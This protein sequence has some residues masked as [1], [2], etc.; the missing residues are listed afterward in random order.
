MIKSSAQLLGE[1]DD[2]ANFIILDTLLG[3]ETH[4]M[5]FIKLPSKPDVNAVK[6]I[7]LMYRKYGDEHTVLNELINLLGSWWH[8]FKTSHSAPQV[9]TQKEHLLHYMRIFDPDSGFA[10]VP[11]TRYTTEEVGAKV[12][13]T[14]KWES[15]AKIKY[16]VGCIAEL[17]EEEETKLLVPGENDFSVMF[18]TRKNCSQLWLGPAA[19]IN[20]DCRPNCKFVS[21][22]RDTACIKVLRDVEIG[23]ELACYYGDDYFG[24]NNIYCECET[25]E[26]RKTGFFVNFNNVNSNNNKE[27]SSGKY[28]L[29]ETVKRLS[30]KPKIVEGKGKHP[31]EKPSQQ[32]VQKEE[33]SFEK[34]CT[35]CLSVIARGL[36]HNCKEATRR[37]NLK[38][39]AL[40]DPLG[41]EQI[42]SFIVSSKE[43]SSDGTILISRFHGKPLEI[44]PG[45][46]AT[47]GLSS[48]PLTTQDMINIQQN[49]GLSNNGMRKL[50]SALNQISP[51]RIVE[52]NF[53]Q[54]FAAAETTLKSFFT[55][56]TSQLPESNETRHIVHCTNLETLK[57]NIVSSRGLQN[58][59]FLKLGID[60]G[61]SFFKASLSLISEHEGEPHSPVQ[62]KSKLI[63]KDNFK[64]TKSNET[65]HIVHCTNLETLKENI[66]SSRGL[67]NSNFLKLG[68]DG[69]GSFFK[70]SLSLIS[71][72]E[73]EPH[74]PVQK[75]SKLITKDNFKNTSVQK[76]LIVT[77]SE[78]TPETYPNVKHILDLLQINEI[79]ISE[80]LVI[81]C[82]MKLANIVCGIQSHSSKHPCCWCNIDS[83]HLENCG[84][85]R[86]FGGIRDLYKKFVKSGCDAKRSKEFENVVHLPMFA[87]PDRELILET[88]PPMELHLLL[89]VVNHLIKYLVQVFPKTKQW[90]DSIHIQMQPFH[91]GHFNGKDCMKVLRKIEELMQ[92]TIAE[93]APDA[94]KAC[95]ALSS[96][97]QVVVSCFGYTLLPDYEAKI[98]DFKDN[99][100]KLP[101][102]VT[103]KA[104]A[105]FHHVQQFIHQHKVGLG[106]FSEQ[107][108]E[109]LHSN[110]KTH[111]QRFKRNSTHPEY[112]SQL[113]S[114][115]VDYNSKKV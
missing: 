104:H 75:K 100:L 109:A 84:Q 85:L 12:L 36:P 60:G 8:S 49:I 64:N 98:C 17:T 4:K 70:A 22:G 24:D 74:S 35:K 37:E 72:H 54:K 97:H 87:F 99:Y 5:G 50:G 66:V 3:Y 113:L 71:E 19:Y 53:Q 41:A 103:P 10:I 111:W 115:V 47:Q 51:V 102:S 14:R 29:R 28:T 93:K 95:Q 96:F 106:V 48:E 81:S 16:L 107:A 63:T 30:R 89:G 2:L 65:R 32:E 67:Q 27:K 88:I 6:S 83:A 44:R 62:K 25:C 112:S 34:R 61:G 69:G 13:S 92:L 77:I 86:T 40:A 91:G 39:L 33:K 78:N 58:S 1:Q 43:V 45:S 105:V 9:I 7:A 82:D 55:V 23:E 38:A 101:V 114:C 57:E 15:G 20:H 11:C 80:K 110:F 108:T 68:I 18:S 73:G 31:F 76:Q 21:T 52:A 94:T 46:N 79:S 90:L 26:R 42:A 56:T 59:N